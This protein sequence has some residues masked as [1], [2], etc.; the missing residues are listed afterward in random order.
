MRNRMMMLGVAVAALTAC[1]NE[2]VSQA[3]TDNPS[4]EP[5][6]LVTIEGC[7]VYRFYDAGHYRYTTICPSGRV[8]RVSSAYSESSG[9]TTVTRVETIDTAERSPSCLPIFRSFGLP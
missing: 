1:A 5:V 4:V 3:S 6:M 9:K 2:P 7:H 8:G